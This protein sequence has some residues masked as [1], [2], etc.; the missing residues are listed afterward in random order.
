MGRNPTPS[1]LHTLRGTA[2]PDRQNPNEPKP[3][4]LSV[5]TEPPSWL[6]DRRARQY[7][8]ELVPMLSTA[9]MLAQTDTT[10]LVILAKAYG[11]WRQ[12]EDFLEANGETYDSKGP[13]A[14]SPPDA[15]EAPAR[16]TS[17]SML[18]PRPEV[19]MRDKA[20]DR[21]VFLLGK[22]GMTPSDRTRVAA[23]PELV[24][25]PSEEFLR[26]RRSA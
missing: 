5:G 14:A 15:E 16:P 2:R 10:A 11:R 9:K 24:G 21:L 20:E 17:P 12:Y 3:P 26:G 13:A 6:R 4:A 22:F 25:D 7:W 8:R 1:A 19:A 23:L 18:R